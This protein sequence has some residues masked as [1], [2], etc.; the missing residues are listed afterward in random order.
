[1]QQGTSKFT[2]RFPQLTPDAKLLQ[3]NVVVEK[4]EKEI[5]QLNE[6]IVFF[7]GYVFL[8]DRDE[9]KKGMVRQLV[10]DNKAIMSSLRDVM[11]HH[12][13]PKC[14][15]IG[16]ADIRRFGDKTISRVILDNMNQGGNSKD[17]Q[18]QWWIDKHLLVEKLLVEHKSQTAQKIKTKYMKGK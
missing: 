5:V 10:K 3:A 12:V 16:K 1:M 14:K 6:A 11:I 15:F 17:E 18:I 2:D 4:L 8:K 9:G 13:F 7:K